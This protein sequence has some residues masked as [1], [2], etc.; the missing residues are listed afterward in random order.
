[1]AHVRRNILTR[2]SSASNPSG[3]NPITIQGADTVIVIMIKTV[4]ATNRA[5][6][7]PYLSTTALN[8]AGNPYV[9]LQANSTQKAVT[10]P[11][12]SAELWYLVNPPA[13]ADYGIFIPNTGLAT[14]FFTVEAGQAQAGMASA[15]DGANG[16]NN[17]AIN[18][19]PG[20]I[21]TTGNGDILFAIT[22]GGWTSFGT[23]TASQTSIAITDDGADGGGE[24][25]MIQA[26]AGSATL[27]W[28][29]GTSDDWGA[30]AAAFK[31]VPKNAFSNNYQFVTVPNGMSTSGRI[32]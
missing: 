5:G 10:T 2:T 13:S 31:E 4:G 30:V 6:G 27:S 29:M 20:A 32:K 7:A 3:S 16:A 1:M 28:T 22:A 17:T 18:P 11:E 9:F 8:P 24:Q 14:L 25:Y 15:F 23:A 21:V 26:S 19:S 12:A